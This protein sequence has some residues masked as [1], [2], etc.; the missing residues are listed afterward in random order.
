MA[1][2]LAACVTLGTVLAPADGMVYAA[3][4]ATEKAKVVETGEIS[5]AAEVTEATEVSETEE[6]TESTEATGTTEA[7]ETLEATETTEAEEEKEETGATEVTET[8][9]VTEVTETEE[10]TEATEETESTEVPEMPAF[11]TG[12]RLPMEF[13]DVP[14][15][16]ID[17]SDIYEVTEDM[18][19]SAVYNTDWDKY[20]NNYFYNRMST[21]ARAFWDALDSMCR[22]YLTTTKSVSYDSTYQAYIMDYVTSSS[23]TK[24]EVRE[25]YYI[26]RYSNPQ[27]YF[28]NSSCLLGSYG[29]SYLIAPVMYSKFADGAA[30]A[31]ATAAVQSQVDSWQS[32]INACANDEQ[33][34]KLIHDLIIRKVEYNDAIYDSDFDEDTQYTQSAYSVFCTDLTVCAGYSQAFEMMCNGSGIDALAV[35]SSDHEWNKVRV[36]DSWYNVDCTWDDQGNSYPVYYDFFARNDAYYDSAS[37][38]SSHQEESYWNKYLPLCTLDSTYSG[39]NTG[40]FPTITQQTAAPQ[41]VAE[42]DSEGDCEVTITS[43]NPDAAIYY[44]IDGTD[45]SESATKSLKY[46]SSFYVTASSVNIRAIAVCNAYL[47]SAVTAATVTPSKKCTITFKGNGATSGSMSSQTA[48]TNSTFTLKKNAFKRSG[49]SFVGWNTQKNGKGTSY[50]NQQTINNLTGD[51][52]LYAQWKLPSY[53]ITYKLNGG[54]NNKK[55]PSSYTRANKV[56][57]KN[58]TKKG[59]T[60]K[61]WYK[62][63]KYKN[64]ITTIKKGSTGKITLY[65]KWQ[66]NTYTVKF[67]GNGSTGG[68]MNSLTA[69]KYGSSYKL[70]A[71]KFKK[72]GYVFTGWNTKKDGSGKSYSNK[73]KVKNLTTKNKGSVTLYAQWKKK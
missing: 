61:G 6:G 20:S 14:E 4:T 49:Y 67:N 2:F 65:A 62:D 51:L 52:T 15:T 63:K 26:F 11:P 48:Y 16:E 55:N 27:Y 31:T 54:T 64:K 66:A 70:T 45:P 25:V 57:L 71:N 24:S 34:V 32:Q 23:L 43:S 53:K 73:Q 69:R 59:Y 68:K 41:I 33:K 36:N 30:R 40:V 8:T 9:E 39:W 13:I 44:T 37:G 7:T 12:G 17:A 29:N 56:T 18:K 10:E 42:T 58:P 72:K 60:F 19:R 5:Q 47:D 21:S 50:T 3:E 35:T 22:G 46:S 1:L 28:L 38:A